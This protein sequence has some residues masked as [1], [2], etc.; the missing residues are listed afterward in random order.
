M[1]TWEQVYQFTGPG[2]VEIDQM[3]GFVRIV[4]WDQQAVQLKASWPGEGRI[5]DRLEIRTSSN[6]VGL[7]VKPYQSGFLGL[8]NRDSQ[9]DLELFVP[10]ATFC[11]VDTGSGPVTVEGTKG[12]ATIDAGSGRVAVVDV[13]QLK[14]D[15]GSGS[16]QVRQVDGSVYIDTGSGRID[17]EAV[18]GEVTL[19]AG[20]GSIAARRLGQGLRAE[21]G[22]GSITVSDVAGG[23]HLESSSGSISASRI[24]APELQVESGSGSVRLQTVDTRVLSVETG[25]G[26]VE[27]ELV[28]VYDQGGYEIETGS[29]RVVVA[30]PENA[31]FNLEVET[32]GRV[33]YG[34]LPVRVVRQEDEEISA[35]V[36][37]GGPRLAIET[38]S[39]SVSLRP[40]R[41][42]TTDRE[43][44]AT[45]LAEMVKDDPALEQSEQM[46]RILKMVQ[47]GKLS[48]EEAEKLLRAL[49]GEEA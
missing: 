22:S 33:D 43:V 28:R 5:E 24:V 32:H 49:D 8:F 20:S 36:G 19:E 9:L 37:Q 39:G 47:E 45:R 23:V 29:G 40:F 16:V 2:T 7:N 46:A 31:G 15:A 1:Q 44:A 41:G 27:V 38:S 21:T 34:G 25:S 35:I 30:V 26:S 6:Y 11:K 17:L 4:G 48:V 18:T 3:D 12:H 14:V 42:D 10:L 13:T